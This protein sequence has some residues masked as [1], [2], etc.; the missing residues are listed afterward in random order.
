MDARGGR[1][2]RARAPEVRVLVLHERRELAEPIQAGI[3]RA[4][5]AG[6]ARAETGDLHASLAR[7][8]CAL[9]VSGTVLLDLLHH[10]LPAVVVYRLANGRST[11]LARRLLTVPWFASVNLLAGREVYP[12]FCFHGD[13]PLASIDAALHR[14]FADAAWRLDCSAGLDRAAAQLGPPGAAARA[15]AQVLAAVR[16]A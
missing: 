12:E 15:A 16:N 4:G 13:G 5:A 2:L 9:S 8:R 11:F 14:C 3:E 6:W 7:A 10:R 1:R